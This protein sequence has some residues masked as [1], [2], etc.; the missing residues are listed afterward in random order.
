MRAPYM[1]LRMCSSNPHALRM[2]A[3][4]MCSSWEAIEPSW[5]RVL[6]SEL[7]Q[8]SFDELRT[9]VDAERQSRPILPPAH[10]VFAAF[11]S[12]PFEEVRVI[13]LG[14]D[15]YPTPGHAHGLSFSVPHGVPIPGSLRNIYAE[16]ERDLQVPPAPHGNLESWAGQGVL[17][18]NSVLTVRA[19][20]PASHARRGWERLTDLAISSLSSRRSGLVFILWGAAAQRKA[21]LVDAAH[22]LVL[23]SAHPSPLSAYRGFIGCGHFGLANRFLRATPAGR[24]I[25]WASHLSDGDASPPG[26][27]RVQA[28]V[29]EDPAEQKAAPPPP[30]PPPPSPPPPSPSPVAPTPSPTPAAAP[31]AVTASP[32]AGAAPNAP[33]WWWKQL[34]AIE[35]A[36]SSRNAPVDFV[37][38]HAL[39]DRRDGDTA[40]RFQT[41][42]ALVLSSRTRDEAVALAMSRLRAL[43][44]AAGAGG[45]CAASIAALDEDLILRAIDGTSFAKTKAGRLREVAATLVED[46]GG[47]T[48]RDLPELLALPG[49]GPKVA[50]LHMHI[51]WGETA[52]I[53]VDTHVHRIAARLGWTR[54]AK[55][56]EVTRRQL[57]AWMPKEHW[58]PLNP[59]LVG[60]GQQVCADTP[61]CRRCELG[62]AKICPQIGVE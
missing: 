4:R 19:G 32:V 45:F 34:H 53:A 61:A 30:P 16:L 47:D 52:G 1:R 10:Q 42:V 5:A 54:G 35:R 2:H 9:F 26:A 3:L 36:R 11:E 37:G 43:A 15:P 62:A 58:R 29:A 38:C 8:P 18:L 17:L 23:T 25:D 33:V 56:A 59:L 28:A 13:I 49:V 27:E 14:Q 39:G 60:F 21:A 50:H 20:E 46:Y 48:P 57:E 22:H 24:P 31:T 55:N 40:F 41:L 51:A 7:R 12:T 6:A 44:A